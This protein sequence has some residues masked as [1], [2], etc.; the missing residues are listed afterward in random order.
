MEGFAKGIIPE[1][2][3]QPEIF[4]GKVGRER[5][6]KFVKLGHFDKDFVKNTRKRGPAG[7]HFGDFL[8]AV[9]FLIQTQI[10]MT[11]RSPQSQIY[12]H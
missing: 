6:G 2:R 11:F 4:Q 3:A 10:L 5:R 9:L 8:L 1:C 12:C 7:K